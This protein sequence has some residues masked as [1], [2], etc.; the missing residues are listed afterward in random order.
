MKPV[1]PFLEAMA[2]QVC[3]L[4][5]A[6]C[7]NYS[8]LTHSG[9]V[10]WADMKQQL[11]SWLAVI[12]IPDFGIMG[13]EPLVNPEIRQ[14]L[15][16]VRELMPNSQIRFTTN[17]LLLDKYFDVVDLAHDVGNIVFKITVHQDTA[18]IENTID[19]IFKRYNWEPVTEYGIRRWAGANGVRFQVNRPDVFLKTYQGTYAD[20]RPWNNNPADSFDVCIQQTCPLLYQG[21]IYKCSTQGLLKDTLAKF[22]NPNLDLWQPY[23]LDGIS[24]DSDDIVVRSFIDNFAK[25]HSMCSMCPSS[26]D[27]EAKLA[28]KIN[29]KR[30]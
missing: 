18:E 19:R 17:G 6:G 10:R 27:T 5:C 26:N 23:L 15:Q 16:G 20:M 21:R 24:P 2:T 30:K 1:L 14:W 22:D 13:G 7:T 9:Y 25:P 8:D 4:S 29:V 28:H 3:N 12:D 11:E